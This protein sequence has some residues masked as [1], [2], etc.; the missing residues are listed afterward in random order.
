MIKFLTIFAIFIILLN[1]VDAKSLDR[2]SSA[3][4]RDGYEPTKDR[5]M[6]K[7][8]PG[9]KPPMDR[10][11]RKPTKGGGSGEP[12]KDRKIRE[13]SKN[14]SG[15]PKDRKIREPTKGG[16]GAPGWKG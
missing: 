16:S 7:P 10:E 6:R 8:N 12:P 3:P 14:G 2:Q 13:P 15:A 11:I 1:D 4:Q 9:S 5:T